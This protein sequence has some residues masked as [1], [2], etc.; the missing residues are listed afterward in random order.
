MKTSMN[1]SQLKKLFFSPWL[2]K[3][4]YV[5]KAGFIT[6]WRMPCSR[7]QIYKQ[8]SNTFIS[9]AKLKLAKI[10]QKLSN[11]LRLNFRQKSPNKQVGKF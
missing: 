11:T 2:P 3:R 1:F 4:F 8:I 5:G 10:T 6:K 9:T 7:I